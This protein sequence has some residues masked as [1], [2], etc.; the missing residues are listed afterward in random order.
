MQICT[1]VEM[2]YLEQSDLLGLYKQLEVLFIIFDPRGQKFQFSGNFFHS[3]NMFHNISHWLKPK[4]W[5][6]FCRTHFSKN[7]TSYCPLWDL[8]FDLWKKHFQLLSYSQNM[9][10]NSSHLLETKTTNWINY[11]QPKREIHFFSEK[12]RSRPEAQRRGHYFL[13]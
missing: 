11:N 7:F 4:N 2:I 8:Y 13:R 5:E 9:F 1:A 12:N 6:K 10:Q 3:Q